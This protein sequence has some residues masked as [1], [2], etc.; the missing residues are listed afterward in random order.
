MNQSSFL[1]HSLK[2][3]SSSVRGFPALRSFILSNACL[4]V[5]SLL[6]HYLSYFDVQSEVYCGGFRVSDDLDGIV[7]VFLSIDGQIVDNTY[8]HASEV[9]PFTFQS[10]PITVKP[11]LG[12]GRQP[13]EFPG[14]FPDVAGL[15]DIGQIRQSSAQ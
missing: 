9:N 7:H 6:H 13:G 11:L 2:V 4:H 5:N 3:Q 14:V 8:I 15:Q 12:V 10:T 1:G